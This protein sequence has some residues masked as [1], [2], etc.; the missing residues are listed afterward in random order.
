MKVIA[1][2]EDKLDG[3]RWRLEKGEEKSPWCSRYDGILV[4]T[5]KDGTKWGLVTQYW[6]GKESQSLPTETPFQ[7]VVY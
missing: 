6:Q 1:N 7:I 3:F 5:F 2:M 4:H